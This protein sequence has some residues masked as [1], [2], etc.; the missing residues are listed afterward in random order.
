MICAMTFSVCP[1]AE[2]Q[3]VIVQNADSIVIV[4]SG[5]RM[6][7]VSDATYFGVPRPI[8]ENIRTKLKVGE[9]CEKIAVNEEQ[10]RKWTTAGVFVS[11]LIIGC[12]IWR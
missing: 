8:M 4:P 5:W 9:D 2:A 12:L 3:A 1:N 6:V 10:K 7:N 11:G